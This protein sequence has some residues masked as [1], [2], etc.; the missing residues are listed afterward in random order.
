MDNNLFTKRLCQLMLQDY[1]GYKIRE[2]PDVLNTIREQLRFRIS[3]LEI[4]IPKL[5][6][7]YREMV[8]DKNSDSVKRM[9]IGN[10]KL[11]LS[12][13]ADELRRTVQNEDT[14]V[15]ISRR[16]Y[17]NTEELRS[18]LSEQHQIIELLW[19]HLTIK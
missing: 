18:S 10:R 11:S 12:Q 6:S 17:S 1:H 13:E 2:N 15:L 16:E 19:G 8:A 9:E 5:D 14:L 3:E 4:E 7:E